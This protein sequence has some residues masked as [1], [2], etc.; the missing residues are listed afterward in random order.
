MGNMELSDDKSYRT[1]DD[2]GDSDGGDGEEYETASDDSLPDRNS[3][4]GYD[5]EGGPNDDRKRY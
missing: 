3:G 1:I 4:G 5:F 2:D